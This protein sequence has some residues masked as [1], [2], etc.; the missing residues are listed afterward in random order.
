M[1][2]YGMVSGET[3]YQFFHVFVVDRVQVHEPVWMIT[4]HFQI[5]LQHLAG[6][7]NVVLVDTKESKF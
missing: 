6:L 7:G 2:T 1:K 4:P 5:F 3:T